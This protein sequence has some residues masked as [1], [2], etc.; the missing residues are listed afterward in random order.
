[1]YDPSSGNFF[2]MSRGI[3]VL[4]FIKQMTFLILHGLIPFKF[5]SSKMTISKIQQKLSKGYFCLGL[6]FWGL[7]AI[8]LSQYIVLHH[9]CCNSSINYVLLRV[10]SQ[11]NLVIQRLVIRSF[12]FSVMGVPNIVCKFYLM[13]YLIFYYQCIVP[14]NSFFKETLQ[15]ELF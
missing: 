15:S 8:I 10:S 13:K 12:N 2:D 9:F 5:R 1:M 6:W 14:V 4:T 3:L 7:F 11:I